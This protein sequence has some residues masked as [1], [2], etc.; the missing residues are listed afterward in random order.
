MESFFKGIPSGQFPVLHFQHVQALVLARAQGQLDITLISKHKLCFDTCRLNHL[1]IL[2]L[3]LGLERNQIKLAQLWR[4][5]Q[6]QAFAQ[7]CASK[8]RACIA[9][10]QFRIDSNGASDIGNE[11]SA[12]RRITQRVIHEIFVHRSLDRLRKTHL[13]RLHSFSHCH[14]P[15]CFQCRCRS[16]MPE[17]Q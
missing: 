11:A 15:P 2:V 14:L 17:F 3:C 12:A 16:C 1:A 9:L 8:D 13:L 6:V 7:Q 4:G 5:L 10:L